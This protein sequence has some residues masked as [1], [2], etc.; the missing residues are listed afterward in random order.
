M[1]A[2]AIS[3]S[4]AVPRRKIELQI[5]PETIAFMAIWLFIGMVAAYDTYL[6]VKF[7]DLM[8]YLELNPLGHWLMQMDGGSVAIF[9]GCKFAGTVL[10]LGVVPLLYLIRPLLGMF[11]AGALTSVQFCLVMFLL[12]A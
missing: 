11:V 7:Q 9:L 1:D 10:V 12:F 8:I 6:T 5:G 4:V 3:R 2:L